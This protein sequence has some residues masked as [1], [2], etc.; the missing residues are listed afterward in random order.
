MTTQH[1]YQG[2]CPD[3][4]QPDVRD[5][6]CPVCLRLD[7]DAL[8]LAALRAARPDDPFGLRE[9]RERLG[10]NHPARL[11]DALEAVLRAHDVLDGNNA[12][13]GIGDCLCLLCGSGEY[14][15]IE[16]IQHEPHCPLVELRTAI[17][18]LKAVL[19][20]D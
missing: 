1:I 2:H 13:D 8:E 12:E 14:D 10:L 4:L 3:V 18:L 16:G 11:R 17:R 5:A 6:N 19:N 7:L 9:L 20:G 15:S